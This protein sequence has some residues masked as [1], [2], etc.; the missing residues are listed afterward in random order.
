LNHRGHRAETEGD[1]FSCFIS[2]FS[3]LILVARFVRSGISGERCSFI[4]AGALTA[5]GAKIA[6]RFLTADKTDIHRWEHQREF[7]SAVIRAD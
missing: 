4:A 1:D 2:Y 7:P 5:K 3:F 6:K